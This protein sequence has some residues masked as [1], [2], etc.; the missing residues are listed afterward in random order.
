MSF[1]GL[2]LNNATPILLQFRLK[3]F[4]SIGWLLKCYLVH[5]DAL[6]ASHKDELWNTFKLCSIL[7][8]SYLWVLKNFHMIRVCVLYVSTAC[9]FTMNIYV[10]LLAF[11]IN[12][13]SV[14]LWFPLQSVL[15]KV[16]AQDAPQISDSIMAALL[17]M[18]ST[19]SGKAGGVQE[20]ALLAVS[21]LIEG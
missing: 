8:L 7:R 14:Y 18:L 19:S 13:T 5:K 4:T 21:T 9:F 6:E 16:S 20:D 10:K 12:S 2:K 15:R 11:E 3:V 17:Q 1:C